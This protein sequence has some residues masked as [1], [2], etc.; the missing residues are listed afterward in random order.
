MKQTFK[1][2]SSVR[3]TVIDYL[4]NSVIPARDASQLIS[5]LLKLEVLKKDEDFMAEME[6]APKPVK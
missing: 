6:D 5:L 2:P 1:L 3:Q 4:Q